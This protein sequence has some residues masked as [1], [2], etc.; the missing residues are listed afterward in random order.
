MIFWLLKQPERWQAL[1]DRPQLAPQLIEESLRRDAAVPGL[2]RVATEDMTF[3]GVSIAKDSRLFLAFG[4]ANHDE[5]VFPEPT[6]F[7]IERKNLHKHMAFGQG[8]HF[9]VGAP[10]ARLEA[11]ITLEVLSQRLP[12][13]RFQPNQPVTYRP[14][15]VL[16]GPEHLQL[17]WGVA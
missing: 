14:N 4:S 6:H 9:C 17:R 7:D 5:T 10:L 2:M 12:N 8:I 3:K 16:R 13:L 1:C 11:R 15:L